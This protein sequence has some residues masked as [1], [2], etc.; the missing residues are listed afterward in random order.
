MRY[1]YTMKQLKTFTDDRGS[2]TVLEGGIDVPFAI[3]RVYWLHHVGKDKT[4][5]S[6]ANRTSTQFLVAIAGSVDVALEDI[7]GKRTVH[8]CSNSEGL[9]LPP[10]TWNELSNFSEDAVVMVFS[11]QPYKPE[12]YLNTYEEFQTFIHQP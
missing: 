7:H 11:S 2:L 8:L 4:R 9:L 1:Y 5:G 3:A 12:T 6:H 10:G